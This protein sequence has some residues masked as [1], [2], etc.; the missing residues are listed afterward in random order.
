MKTKKIKIFAAARGFYGRRKNCWVQAVRSVHKAWQYAYI[1][2]KLKKRDFR[3]QW[4]M[5]INAGARLCGFTYSSLIRWMPAAGMIMNRKVLADLARTE[6][7]TFRAVVEAARLAAGP[8]AAA[9]P[10]AQLK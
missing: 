7:Y 1:G 8:A 5:Q 4:I 2:R 10:A 3:T 6:P 9:A